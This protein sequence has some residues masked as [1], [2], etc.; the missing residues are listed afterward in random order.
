MWIVLAFRAL[1][2]AAMALAT[3]VLGALCFAIR[4]AR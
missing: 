1:A 4:R 3:M 2:V